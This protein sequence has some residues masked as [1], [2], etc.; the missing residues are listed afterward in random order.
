MNNLNKDGLLL[1]YKEF[2]CKLILDENWNVLLFELNLIYNKNLL[3]AL[4]KENCFFLQTISSKDSII[5]LED[6]PIE[7]F[8]SGFEDFEEKVEELNSQAINYYIY[9]KY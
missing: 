2:P 9:D 1:T 3:K 4:S 7:F 5:K 8:F 6:E